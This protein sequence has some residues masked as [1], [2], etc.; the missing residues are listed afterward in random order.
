[1]KHTRRLGGVIFSTSLFDISYDY[2]YVI[3]GHSTEV[4]LEQ[5]FVARFVYYP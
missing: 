5:V 1:M 2:A 3:D 4:A